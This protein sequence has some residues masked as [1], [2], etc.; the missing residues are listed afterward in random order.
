MKFKKGCIPWNKGLTKETDIRLKELGRKISKISKGRK[1][2]DLSNRNRLNIREKNPFW[3]PDWN[4]LSRYQKHE[5]MMYVITKTDYCW[6]CKKKIEKLAF[7]NK[8]H[9]YR[10]CLEDWQWVCYKCHWQWDY[11]H[12]NRNRAG[13]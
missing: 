12:N 5:R 1:R 13:P 2:P 9:K 3:Q 7:S 11:K 6:I 10:N 8:D 4:K